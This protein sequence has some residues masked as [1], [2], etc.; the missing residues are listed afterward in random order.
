MS[1]LKVDELQFTSGV[2]QYTAKAWVTIWGTNGAGASVASSGNVSSITDDGIGLYTSNFAN[3]MNNVY[4]NTTMAFSDEV[5]VAH[6]VGFIVNGYVLSRLYT[7]T[8][9]R[10][11]YWNTT[12]SGNRIDKGTVCLSFFE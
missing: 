8:Q 2:R 9:C 12:N 6:T 7:T 3:A 10:T 11:G 4:Y 1:I 5:S